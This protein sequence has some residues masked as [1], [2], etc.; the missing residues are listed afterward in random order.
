LP[1]ER[2][3]DQAPFSADSYAEQ[4]I[5]LTAATTA[6]L[7]AFAQQRRLTLNTL[8][9]GAWALLLSHTSGQPDVVFGVTITDRP[10]DL[11]GVEAMLG[12][13]INTL[14]LRVA[15]PLDQTLA[16]W[17]EKIQDQQ[18]EQRQYA[19][20]SLTQIQAW[21]EVPPAWPLFSSF[22]RFQNYPL[23]VSRWKPDQLGPFEIQTV[24]EVDWWPYPV[25]LVAVPGT[26]LL[27]RIAYHQQLLRA[28]TITQMLIQLQ[29]L[30]EGFLV[31]PAP[32][33][34]SVL[35]QIELQN[36]DP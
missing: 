4:Q 11:P 10:A 15:L 13:F 20:V 31:D 5:R 21:S 26:E 32:L 23:G 27:L 1:M 35:R 14:P 7:Q 30:L 9:Q 34:G 18:V 19:Y 22:L 6:G 33:L 3:A 12:L 36:A 25:G 29:K 24:R 8:V 17:L 16:A 28:V 2:A